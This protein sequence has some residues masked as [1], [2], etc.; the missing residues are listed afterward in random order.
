MID[1]FWYSHY[2]D[3]SFYVSYYQKEIATL[4]KKNKKR[5][6]QISLRTYLGQGISNLLPT[7]VL[8]H[9]YLEKN[10]YQGDEKFKLYFMTE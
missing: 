1:P 8:P 10:Y 7:K 5:K 2:H 9:I 6:K 3:E 4:L